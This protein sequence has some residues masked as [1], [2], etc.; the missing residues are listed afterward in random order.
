MARDEAEFRR[1]H[2]EF[3]ATHGAV[4]VK[5]TNSA[6]HLL[7]RAPPMSASAE[8]GLLLRAKFGPENIEGELVFHPTRKWRWDW[9]FPKLK[10]GI[11]IQG[12]GR[13]Q[14]YVG[15]REDCEKLNAAVLLGWRP[16]W[17]VAAERKHISDWVDTITLAVCR[18]PDVEP[19]V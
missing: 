1:L 15:Y 14:R 18:M 10:L 16:L 19:D 2:A 8:L 3:E 9:A 11:E 7:L 6:T 17:F 5:R 4:K 13:H 12:Q